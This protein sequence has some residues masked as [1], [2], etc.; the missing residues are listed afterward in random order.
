[1]LEL[2]VSMFA[3][4]AETVKESTI[5]SAIGFAHYRRQG[6]FAA[7]D[8]DPLGP[9]VRIGLCGN[10]QHVETAAPD[11]PSCEVC[12][13]PAGIGERDYRAVDLRQP[14]GFMSYFTRARDYDGVF[15]FVPR[16]ARPK[17]GSPAFAM[18]QQ[19]N[20]E[21]GSGESRL[22]VINDNGGRLF[23]LAPPPWT[24]GG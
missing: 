8:P 5:H 15:D 10:C 12:A 13:Q 16:A 19:M 23:Q 6:H 3:P 9:A 11:S 22:H 4:G 18:H 14:K 2:A 20:F 1:D 17:A 21:V 24:P 7:L